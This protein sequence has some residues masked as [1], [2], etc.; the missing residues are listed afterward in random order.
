MGPRPNPMSRVL[1][2]PNDLAASNSESITPFLYL[3]S[4]FSLR[5]IH[6]YYISC[7][8]N[9][10]LEIRYSMPPRE[11]P[12]TPCQ[13]S[14]DSTTESLTA[15]SDSLS[16]R[17]GATIPTFDS[18]TCALLLLPRS[19]LPLLYAIVI[20]C[21]FS[22]QALNWNSYMGN[23]FS[24]DSIHTKVENNFLFSVVFMKAKDESYATGG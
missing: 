22:L 2:S 14:S 19:I 16:T 13:R 23:L 7:C 6:L 10:M 21:I 8:A 17:Y 11:L 9:A 24:S 15:R 12:V 3:S 20:A 4:E 18:F 5:W 1:K